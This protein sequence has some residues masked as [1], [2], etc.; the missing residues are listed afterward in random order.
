M[1]SRAPTR[2]SSCVKQHKPNEIN[3]RSQSL[4]Q[5]S[6]YCC[7]CASRTIMFPSLFS[8]I[9]LAPAEPTNGEQHLHASNTCTR[10]SR[11][12]LNTALSWQWPCDGSARSSRAVQLRARARGRG[13]HCHCSWISGWRRRARRLLHSLS[14]ISELYKESQ[15]GPTFCYHTSDHVHEPWRTICMLCLNVPSSRAKRHR[16][17]PSF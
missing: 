17:A 7:S 14:Y 12:K 1:R 9:W 10:T 3:S 6:E 8:W 5:T 13:A 4:C 2:A 16:I 15:L 11:L